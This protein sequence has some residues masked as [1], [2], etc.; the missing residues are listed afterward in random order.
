[1][2]ENIFLLSKT[3]YIIMHINNIKTIQFGLKVPTSYTPSP[4]NNSPIT[5]DP[6]IDYLCELIADYYIL[7]LKK[8]NGAKQQ[9]NNTIVQTNHQSYEDANELYKEEYMKIIN[10]SVGILST[11]FIIYSIL[12]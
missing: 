9:I 2:G 12:K 11:G 7:L 3:F 10:I 8:S 4:Y 6:D 5:Y 1:M